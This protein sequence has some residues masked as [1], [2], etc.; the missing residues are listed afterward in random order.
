ME[1]DFKGTEYEGVL[2]LCGSGCGAVAGCYECGSETE[3]PIKYVA[4]L[5]NI[6]DYWIIKENY[7]KFP[8][9]ESHFC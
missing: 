1:V 8:L 6:G 3:D 7:T 4:F 2:D 5:E 9:I